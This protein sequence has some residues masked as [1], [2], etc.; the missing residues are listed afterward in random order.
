MNN[1]TALVSCT[2]PRPWPPLEDIPFLILQTDAM[3]QCRIIAYPDGHLRFMMMR[4][5]AQL[6][7]YETQ[8][9]LVVGDGYAVVAV[10]WDGPVLTV[11]INGQALHALEATTEVF[12]VNTSDRERV[13]QGT[14]LSLNTPAAR[15]RCHNWMEWRKHRYGNTKGAAK[16]GRRLKTTAEQSV[17]LQNAM[18]AL[19]EITY[20][21]SV[22]KLHFL[23]NIA[24]QLRSLVYWKETGSTYNPLLLRLA[25]RLALPLPVFAYPVSVTG[26][27]IGNDISLP[28]YAFMGYGAT[29]QRTN[30]QQELMDIQAWLESPAQIERFEDLPLSAT[31]EMK[32]SMTVN[33]II[34]ESSTNFGIAHYDDDI[35]ESLDRLRNIKATEIELLTMFLLSSASVVISLG[36]YVL[37]EL[38]TKGKL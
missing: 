20:F 4:G 13:E 12:V 10:T 11:Y 2:F 8:P 5:D 34:L 6:G 24:A 37:A 25:G 29:I 38:R 33:Q 18:G 32:S 36:N 35:P 30:P 1:G 26:L 7:I 15:I 16:K 31:S 21:I 9:I 28:T 23:P 22:G 27:N 17:E 3:T 19:S 14:Q